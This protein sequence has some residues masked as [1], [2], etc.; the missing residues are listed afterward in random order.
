MIR[1]N[2]RVGETLFIGGTR[3]IVERIAGQRVD[4]VIDPE[5]GVEVVRSKEKDVGPAPPR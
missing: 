2:R 4:L 5:P 3:V 1:I